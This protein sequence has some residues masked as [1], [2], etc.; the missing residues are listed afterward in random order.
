MNT[1]KTDDGMKTVYNPTSID[2]AEQALGAGKAISKQWMDRIEEKNAPL[3]TAM[4]G[5]SPSQRLL[6][7]TLGAM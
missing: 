7:N 5:A 6:N 2:D 4:S 3:V 1:I